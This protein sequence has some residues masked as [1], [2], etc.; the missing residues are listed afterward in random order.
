MI[1]FAL[2]VSFM[3]GWIAHKLADMC[4]RKREEDVNE[5]H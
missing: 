5:K 2:I 3:L 4:D 1:L